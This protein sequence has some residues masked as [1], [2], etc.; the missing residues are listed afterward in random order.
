[1]STSSRT[2][3]QLDVSRFN[4]RTCSS[5]YVHRSVRTRPG[6]SNERAVGVRA[7]HMQR[8]RDEKF[9]AA[10][11]HAANCPRRAGKL[12]CPELHNSQPTTRGAHQPPAPPLSD[13]RVLLKRVQR[14]VV[15]HVVERVV[16]FDHAEV[17]AGRDAVLRLAQRR[18]G[19]VTCAGEGRASGSR[20][21]SSR[22]RRMRGVRRG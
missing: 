16:E 3:S 20:R 12:G 4:T 1:M 9:R 8:P 22:A 17:A 7:L 14:R 11:R 6:T 13:L 15:R 21:R 18:D 19:R 5:Q 10:Q 2:L